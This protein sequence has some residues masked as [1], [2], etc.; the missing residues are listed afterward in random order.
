MIIYRY[1]QWLILWNFEFLISGALYN[2]WENKKTSCFTD[3]PI[4][5]WIIDYHFWQTFPAKCN[6]RK[7]AWAYPNEAPYSYSTL[8]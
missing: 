5:G 1:L 7:N 3:E 2:K 6:V 4:L 8:G